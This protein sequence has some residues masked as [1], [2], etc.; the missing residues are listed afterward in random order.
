MINEGGPCEGRLFYLK[1]SECRSCPGF[2][3]MN[4]A[5]FCRRAH[6]LVRNRLDVT[7]TEPGENC[8]EESDKDEV[9]NNHQYDCRKQYNDQHIR[10][11]FLFRFHDS[12][13]F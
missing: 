9:D 10:L 4:L 2:R 8:R 5:D 3:H 7:G 6:L 13:V 1:Y 12:V 11:I